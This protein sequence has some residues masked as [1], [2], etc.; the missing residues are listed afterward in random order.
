[1]NTTK[2]KGDGMKNVLIEESLKEC[3]MRKWELADLLGIHCST[4]SVKL[5]HELPKE[6][7]KRIVQLI[8]DHRN[9]GR[10]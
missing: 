4:L 2:K 1:M 6:E 8:I 5:R 3:G 7:Q 10:G 9:N